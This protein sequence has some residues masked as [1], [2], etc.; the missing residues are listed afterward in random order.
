MPALEEAKRIAEKVTGLGRPG[1][2]AVSQLV[3][4]RK[5]ITFQFAD[6]GETPNNPN[7]PLVIYRS[8]VSLRS[9][10]D[11]A[12]TFEDLFASNGWGNSWRDGIYGFLRIHTR[13][14]EVLGIARGSVQVAFGGARGKHL[15]LKAGD[16]AILPAGTG[17]RCIEAS[18]DLL[19]VGAYPQNSGAYDQPKPGRQG[20]REA[21]RSIRNVPAPRADPVYG[22]GSPAD[23][24]LAP[25]AANL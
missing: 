9:K 24:A 16:A 25:R 22:P 3:R 13:S 1:G 4:A 17:H 19:V 12:A 18:D 21:V 15:R 23:H 8:P 6:D 10:F 2:E 14:H 5:P 20:S 7:W 11:P